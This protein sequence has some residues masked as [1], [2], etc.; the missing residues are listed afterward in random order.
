M[1]DSV[2]FLLKGKFCNLWIYKKWMALENEKKKHWRL[3]ALCNNQ[4]NSVN[5]ATLPDSTYKIHNSQEPEYFPKKYK[6]DSLYE[7]V[8]LN[9]HEVFQ[10]KSQS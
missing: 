9:S 4:I 10:L 6:K 8:L 5:L 3:Q 1:N 2:N 7:I